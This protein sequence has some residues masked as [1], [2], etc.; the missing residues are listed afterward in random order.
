MLAATLLDPSRGSSKLDNLALSVLNYQMVPI[1]SLIGER[2]DPEQRSMESV[3][4]DQM[5]QYAAEDADIALRLYYALIPVL[6]ENGMAELVCEIEAPLAIVIAEMEANGILV[7][8]EELIR[9]GKALGSRVEE[10][11]TQIREAAGFDF[12]LNSTRQLA[13]ALFDRLGLK[14]GKKTKTGRSTDVEVLEKLASEEDRTKPHTAVPRLILEY[15]QLQKLISTYL[16][17]LRAAIDAKTGRIHSTFHQLVTATG[18][19]AS[20][21]PN[22]QNIP[23]RSE[24]G[25]EIRRAFYS[26]PGHSLICADYSQI[27]LRLLAHLSG[28]EALISAFEKDLDIHAAVASEVFGVPLEEVTRE[29]RNR[30]KTINFGIIY[31]VTPYGL[32]RR[33]EGLDLEAATTLIADY[34]RRYSGIDS[35]LNG[36]IAQ[37]LSN[38]FVTTIRGRRRSISE[39]HGSSANIRSLGERLAINSVVQGSAADLIKIAMVNVQKRIHQESRPVKLLLQIHDELIFETPT[40][41][42]EAQAKVIQEVMES[43]MSLRVPLRVDYGIGSTWRDAK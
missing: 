2:S 30:A 35:F 23:V 20:H 38:G 1:S 10:L 12:D 7:D 32:S 4:L 37:A 25:R 21:N 40:E 15:R 33:V 24:I 5:T 13:E 26:A 29:Q 16:G 42:A 34:K 17:N 28:D 39:I 19:L 3:E 9:Q 43:A 22:L 27:E 36:C 41:G 31:G 14:A 18:R 6:K 11:R 8:P